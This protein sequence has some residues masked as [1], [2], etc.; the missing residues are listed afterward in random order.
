MTP[1]R[2]PFVISPRVLMRGAD[3][4]YLFLRRSHLS[5]NFAG[6]WEPPGGK[7]DAGEAI[8]ETLEREVAEETGLK[9]T[10][11]SVAGAVQGETPRAKFVAVMME[12][13]V[14]SGQVHLSEEH[15]DF[16]WATPAEAAQLDLS[17]I[18]LPFVKSWAASKMT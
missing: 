13:V 14:E 16:I 10:D 5:E 11:L 15:D 17:P 6:H 4:R 18:Y 9:I 12:A 7:M 1:G 8:D 2:K 3:G